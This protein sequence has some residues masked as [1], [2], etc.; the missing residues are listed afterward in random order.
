MKRISRI[1]SVL[2]FVLGTF[3]LLA[4]GARTAISV[5]NL[6]E[7]ND[8][9]NHTLI[10]LERVEDVEGL[11]VDTEAGLRGYI[12]TGEENYLEAYKAAMSPENGLS[13]HFQKLRQLT[14]DNPGQQ[15]RLDALEPLVAEALALM[16]D[17]ID[18]R[19]SESLDPARQTILTNEDKQKM[20]E[21][22]GLLIDMQQVELELLQ[23]R[24]LA[25]A[26]NLQTVRLAVIAG[27]GLPLVLLWLSFYVLQRELGRRRKAEAALQEVNA[28]LETRVL[29]RTEALFTSERNF[30]NLAETAL[31]G[32]YRT[33][34]AG[35]ILY[36]NPALLRMLGFDSVEAL[37]RADVWARYRRPG[38]RRTL[39]EQLEREGQVESFETDVL[40]R[41]GEVRHVLI[42]ATLTGNQITGTI[43]DITPRREAE[44]SL[45]RN[46]A[47]LT[48]IG[49]IAKVGGWELD[50]ET[51]TLYWTDETYRI[52]EVDPAV[53]PDV[54]SAINFYAPEARPVIRAAVEQAL[55]DGTP[56]DLILPFITAT[57]K[58]LWVRAQGQAEFHQGRPVRLWGAF[59]DLTELKQAEVALRESRERFDRLVSRLNDVVWTA[60]ADGSRI[61]EVN[62]AFANVYGLPQ[63]ELLANP[64]L[65]LEMVHPD[66]REIAEASSKELFEKGQATAEYRIITPQGEVRWLLDRK[67][68]LFDEQNN[69]IQMGGIASDITER[70]KI[71]EALRQQHRRLALL[72]EIARTTAARIDLPSVFRTTLAHLEEQL[73]V[74]FSLVLL[75]DTMTGSLTFAVCG[76]KSDTL[77]AK[78]GFSPGQPLQPAA[79]GMEGWLVAEQPIYYPD[80]TR[81]DQPFA[82]GLLQGNLRSLIAVPLPISDAEPVGLL[83]VARSRANAFGPDEQTFLKQVAEQV[84]LTAQHVRLY[85]RLLMAYDDLSQTRRALMKEERLNLLGQMASGIAHDINNAL[86]PVVGFTDII[87]MRETSLSEEARINLQRIKTGGEDIAHIVNRMKSFY[88][89][90]DE[91]ETLFPVDLNPIVQQVIDLTRPHWRDIPQKEGVTITVETDLAADLP[92]AQG[93]ESELREALTNLI[94]NAVHAM[95]QGGTITLRTRQ[96]DQ[97]LLLEVIDTGLG[98]DNETRERCLEPFYTTKGQQGGTGLGLSMVYGVMQRHEGTIEIDSAPGR[99]T[100]MRLLFPLREYKAPDE[101]SQQGREIS[102]PSLRILCVDDDP[103]VRELLYEMLTNEGHQPTL[104][105]GGQAGINA[106]QESLTQ[107]EPF[108]LVFTDLGMPYVGGAEVAKAIKQASP[109]TPVILL[110]GWG[111]QLKESEEIPPAVD[112]VMGKPPTLSQMRATLVRAFTL[113]DK[114]EVNH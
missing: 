26:A 85:E 21:I 67:S 22:R 42:S 6:L 77:T 39:L 105:D 87:L 40:T 47:M 23:Q 3:L 34:V 111:R 65:W 79:L 113:L 62:P 70:K 52:H 86:V 80:L 11:L 17:I 29:Q 90:R 7:S 73:P 101:Y 78:L 64:G 75:N 15:R 9:V 37:M 1:S 59:Q 83:V 96:A 102:L 36:A 30:R 106:F 57:G 76:L 55:A 98:M 48:E 43:M 12:I 20:D 71:E 56:W 4:V 54:E 100:T 45:R 32:I 63:E 108:D 31:V 110:S 8:W 81:L 2:G 10:V 35:E 50:V 97:Q 114:G 19:K 16:A 72:N 27:I 38:D 41:S 5:Q 28:T 61:I 93:I 91:Q 18:L 94:I 44:E 33:T 95:P 46:E 66:D 74:D 107:G 51:Q 13:R 82:S 109:Q 69:P 14:M 49:H 25:T 112:I 88:R 53:Q 99:G 89:P 84:A 24:S 104:A 60:T 68:I 103:G 92:P 58:Q